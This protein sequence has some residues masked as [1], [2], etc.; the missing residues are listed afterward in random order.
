MPVEANAE[1]LGKIVSMLHDGVNVE[2]IMQFADIFMVFFEAQ[3]D[4]EENFSMEIIVD[5]FV[6]D[7][8]ILH[9]ALKII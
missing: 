4:L 8:R 3:K 5:A 9:T 6:M 1:F 2:I 7:A